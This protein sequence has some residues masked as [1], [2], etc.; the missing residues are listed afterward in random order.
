MEIG[1]QIRVKVLNVAQGQATLTMK[2]VEDDEDDLKTLNM[3]LKRDWSRGTNAF[4]LAFRRNKGISAFLDQR[5]RTKVSADTS[6]SAPEAESYQEEATPE[7]EESSEELSS[8]SEVATDVSPP[9]SDVSSQDL[10]VHLQATISVELSSNGTPDS[11]IVS[12]VSETA[13]K[14]TEPKESSAVEEVLVTASNE[15]GKEPAADTEAVLALSEKTIAE[16]AA[17]AGVAQ[18]STTTSLKCYEEGRCF[19]GRDTGLT[20]GARGI[21]QSTFDYTTNRNVER[22]VLKRQDTPMPIRKDILGK[23]EPRD[24]HSDVPMLPNPRLMFQVGGN[25]THLVTPSEIISGT[26]SS[27]ENNDASKSDG[28]KSQDVSSRSS[29]VPEVEP[30][31]IDESKQDQNLGLEAVKETQIVCENM[32]KTRSSLDQTVEM[33][34]ERSVTTD[35]YSVEESQSSSDRSTSDQTG[36]SENVLKKFVEMPENIDYSSASREQSSSFTKEKVLHPQTSGQP[37]PPVSAFNSTES[38]EPLSSTYLP[39]TVSS[40]PEVGATQGMLQ[41][42]DQMLDKGMVV[43][44]APQGRQNGFK[45]AANSVEFLESYQPIWQGKENDSGHHSRFY[46]IKGATRHGCHD[47]RRSSKAT[48]SRVSAMH[49]LVHDLL[50]VVHMN[51]PHIG[52]GVGVEAGDM[53]VIPILCTLPPRRH[54]SSL[55]QSRYR[56]MVARGEQ[57][58][59]NLPCW[60][61]HRSQGA[62]VTGPASQDGAIIGPPSSP[63]QICEVE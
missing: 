55:L 51:V 31:H 63:R 53:I 30:K 37:S 46:K 2:G 58:K 24:G 39:V 40:Y 61:S 22:D 16:V 19:L 45:E 43:M 56:S 10:K 20:P 3:E 13:D 5:K 59:A 18:A 4:E 52:M 35:K 12:S 57:S 38:H 21:D 33:I 60:S 48:L 62:A 9:V 32:E 23:D 36:I 41:Q 15:A 44:G 26:L 29:Q 54:L 49:L 34:S 17:A 28:G 6:V 25:A 47:L 7:D 8:V 27:S 1:K 14:P 42:N 50:E 11:S